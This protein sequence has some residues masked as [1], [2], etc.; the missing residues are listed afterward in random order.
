MT[1]ADT[2]ATVHFPA[3]LYGRPS[4]GDAPVRPSWAGRCAREL[5]YQHRW[6]RPWQPTLEEQLRLEMGQRAHEVVQAALLRLWPEG[7]VEAEGLWWDGPYGF[8][9]RLFLGAHADFLYGDGEET[10]AVEIK[11][12]QAP[13]AVKRGPADHHWLQAEL[14]ALACGAHR[15]VVLLVARSNGETASSE[16]EASESIA[17]AEYHRLLGAL[18]SEDV[19]PRIDEHMEHWRCRGCRY[20]SECAFSTTP[21]TGGKS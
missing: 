2:L 11:T 20:V 3:G 4:V 5:W 18:T 8:T 7:T 6:P 12:V 13:W 1:L 17:T 19:P 9:P 16:R 10:V 14:V 15:I 21:K